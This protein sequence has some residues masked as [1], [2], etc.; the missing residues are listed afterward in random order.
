MATK[1]L[2]YL[3]RRLFH[4]FADFSYLGANDHCT[5]LSTGHH[6]VQ[7]LNEFGLGPSYLV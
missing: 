5:S 3:G 2:E 1:L 7:E 4:I 6:P